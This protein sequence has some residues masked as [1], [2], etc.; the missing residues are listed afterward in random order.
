VAGTYAHISLVYLVCRDTTALDS[1][2][3]LTDP[4]KRWLMLNLKFCELGAVSPDYPSLALFDESASAWAN[5]MHYWK[6]ADF[7]R[8]AS[9]IVRGLDFDLPD[10]QRIFAW[11]F[12]FTAHV[13]TDLAIHPIIQMKVGPY[14]ENKRRHRLCELNQ[15]VY[16]FHKLGFG[17]IADANYIRDCGIAACSD[18]TDR[19][20]LNLAVADVWQ[21]I[22][23]MVNLSDAG[24]HLDVPV[25]NT[26]PNPHQWH[27][28]FVRIVDD[29]AQKGGMFPPLAR[30]FLEDEALVYPETVDP[31]FIENLKTPAG[32]PIH[33]DA[34]FAKTQQNVKETWGQLAAALSPDGNSG[35]LTLENGNLDTGLDESSNS[36]YWA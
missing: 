19:K 8:R 29:V 20:K 9:D 4:M 32:I 15:D 12:G 7:I 18:E 5:I 17:E 25:P 30:R 3:S 14:E 1:I 27:K 36:I 13:V 34:V 10:S 2:A 33:Y 26:P 31:D 21:K 35:L 6:T 11:L 24:E 22:L 16:V 23:G 28:D